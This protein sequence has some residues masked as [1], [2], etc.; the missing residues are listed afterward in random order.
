MLTQDCIDKIKDVPLSDV[1][2]HFVP[3]MKKK[4][5]KPSDGVT[6]KWTSKKVK[7]PKTIV[8]PC[9]I[10]Y[11]ITHKGKKY[12]TFASRFKSDLSTEQG[13]L[14]DVLWEGGLQLLHNMEKHAC[15]LK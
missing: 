14:V 12:L 6:R 13:R 2:R 11:T 10:E 9:G 1:I 4:D 15:N 3:D 5:P 8:L 7:K